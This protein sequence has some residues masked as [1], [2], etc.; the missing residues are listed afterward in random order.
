MK[1]HHG[2]PISKR[3]DTH[4]SI[5]PLFNDSPRFW[6]GLPSDEKMGLSTAFHGNDA[7]AVDK[8]SR[9]IVEPCNLRALVKRITGSIE[10]AMQCSADNLP[11]CSNSST[12]VLSSD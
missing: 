10:T 9:A 3:C 11:C 4:K 7:V 1:Q 5:H 12:C 6:A 2:L 8:E